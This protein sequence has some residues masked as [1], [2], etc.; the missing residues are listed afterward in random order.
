MEGRVSEAEA[1]ERGYEEGLQRLPA[2]VIQFK[3]S[4]RSTLALCF[5]Q[6]NAE[7]QLTRIAPGGWRI[8]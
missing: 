1:G 7:N 2:S 3:L 5:D 6:I 8:H 4:V